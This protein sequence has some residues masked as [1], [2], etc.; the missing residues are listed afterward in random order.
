MGK[1]ERCVGVEE[2]NG[3]DVEGSVFGGESERSNEG[4]RDEW[5]ET[6]LDE[7]DGNIHGN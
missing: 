5:N 4:R 1:K 2:R 3:A 6:N 7:G